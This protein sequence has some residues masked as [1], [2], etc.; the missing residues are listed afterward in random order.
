[1]S[2]GYTLPD[3]NQNEVKA[4]IDP[5]TTK[6]DTP[7]L[8]SV[9]QVEPTS[10][11]PVIQH[12]K[13]PWNRN[14]TASVRTH[15]PA[16]SRQ[17]A[18][19]YLSMLKVGL[20]AGIVRQRMTVDGMSVA[21]IDSLFRGVTLDPG[22]AAT[23]GTTTATTTPT[24]SVSESDA[25]STNTGYHTVTSSGA[26]SN[27]VAH[28]GSC[29]RVGL[30]NTNTNKYMTMLKA[31]LSEDV[32]RQRMTI[33]DHLTPEAVEAFFQKLANVP[34]TDTKCD[35]APTT[36]TENTD[37]GITL[38]KYTS[39]LKAGLCAEVIQQKMAL[40]GVA[41]AQIE[42]FFKAH[43]LQST[44]VIDRANSYSSVTKRTMSPEINKPVVNTSRYIKM[45]KAGVS[46]PQVRQRMTIVDHL[47]AEQVQHFFQLIRSSPMAT[48]IP[49]SGAKCGLY[50]FTE[51]IKAGV[52][53]E[54]VRQKMAIDKVAQEVIDAYFSQVQ[55]QSCHPVFLKKYK[56]MLKAGSSATTVE[57]TMRLDGISD[58][59]I[60][61]IKF[62]SAT[63]SLVQTPLCNKCVYSTML[64][65]GLSEAAVRQR[66]SVDGV[67]LTQ[68]DQFFSTHSTP[69][70]LTESRNKTCS[71]KY[72]MMIKAGI[73]EGAVR[74]RMMVVDNLSPPQVDAFFSKISSG[75][76]ATALDQRPLNT[77]ETFK[78]THRCIYSRM[79]KAGLSEAM[80]RQRMH[81]DGVTPFD[82]DAF[83]SEGLTDRCCCTFSSNS[84]ANRDVSLY[85]AMLHVGV[86][87]AA[88]QQRMLL[89]G[90]DKAQVD[91]LFQSQTYKSACASWP[92]TSPSSNS[93]SS[94]AS[95]TSPTA[96]T[97][98]EE[99]TAQPTAAA[100]VT[101]KPSAPVTLYTKM[102]QAGIPAEAVRQRMLV[103]DH[104]TTQQVES[105]FACGNSTATG[106]E[107]LPIITEPP[108]ADVSI[109]T[110]ML[111]VGVCAYAVRQKMAIDG[112]PEHQIEAFFDSH[113]DH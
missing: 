27:P 15:R 58:T 98:T 14:N 12:V 43:Q 11:V 108:P 33:V 111:H 29:I 28:R 41:P 103:T 104:L 83:F 110:A 8:S 32:V 91:A 4:T 42:E 37:Q 64:Q 47:S 89:D 23:T 84:R 22:C 82:V 18:S 17:P 78:L 36:V 88:V 5:P 112:I 1:M 55:E 25:K 26:I 69:A 21:E 60:K 51:M 101:A 44:I 81:V 40:D 99:G 65:V 86:P 93:T 16:G 100:P 2:L 53:I 31:G 20:S 68:I 35:A 66:M 7:A 13:V 9:V 79:L 39:M 50:R 85:I 6:L 105:F 96:T 107:E 109:Y 113:L 3:V 48:A 56:S 95:C 49:C 45:L 52:P 57:Q 106:T 94:S 67:P 75:V 46:E 77:T 72:S 80:V 71:A 70:S 10:P 34:S 54:A 30:T 90:I 102:L 61:E 63:S 92:I 87:E 76:K 97:K 74:Q 73:S 19:V 38:C 24:V 62:P 59:Q